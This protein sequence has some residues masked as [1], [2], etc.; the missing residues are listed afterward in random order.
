MQLIPASH[1]AQHWSAD[2]GR[3]FHEALIETNGHNLSLV[4]SGLEITKIAPGASPFVVPRSG[5]DAKIPLE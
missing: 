5:P 2:M 3:P 4:F 1:E